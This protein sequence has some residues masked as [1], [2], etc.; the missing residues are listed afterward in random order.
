MREEECFECGCNLK[1]CCPG[2]EPTEG[3]KM[4]P[5]Q[6]YESCYT[7]MNQICK[8]QSWGDPFSY[9]RSREIFTANKLGHS[10]AT[11]FSGADAFNKEG[12]PVEYKST[13]GKNIK[14][15]Y[16]GISVQE[17]WD[18][19]ERYIRT[20]KIG[21]YVEHYYSR[22]DEN[23]IA[24]IWSVPGHKVVD[25]LLPKLKKKFPTILTKKDPRLSADVTLNEIQKYGTRV[26]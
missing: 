20:E 25:I 4:T 11:T 13:I 24:E 17:N 10:I 18:E 12:Q 8:E 26:L 23:G 21:K 9:A 5:E 14:G 7:R 6:E 15:S 19:Q 16:T 2:Y 22:F 3:T 1:S